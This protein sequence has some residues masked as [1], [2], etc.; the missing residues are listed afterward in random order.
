M[1]KLK[2]KILLIS[3]LL[4]LL[5]SVQSV[6][7]AADDNG[8]LTSDSIDLSICDNT[9]DVSSDKLSDNPDNILTASNELDV[10]GVDEAT[11]SNL[12]DEISAGGNVELQ[13]DYYRCSGGE[14][15]I[16]ISG[17]NRIIDGKGA[18]I[19]MAGSTIQAFNVVGS[20]VTIK[21]LTIKNA[22]YDGYGG[23]IYLYGTDNVVSNCN[24]TNNSA[25][26]GGAIYSGYFFATQEVR[27]CNFADNKATAE[28]GTGGAIYFYRATGTVENCN[29]NNNKAGGAIYCSNFDMAN[30]IVTNCNFTN[31]YA[32]EGGA[33]H[34]SVAS[35][36]NCK[37]TNNTASVYTGGAI[38]CS[39]ATVTNCNFTGNNAYRGSAIYSV[40]PSNII[41]STFLNNRANAT[42][43]KVT[44]NEANIIITF[45]GEDNLLNAIYFGYDGEFDFTNVTY[46]GADGIANTGN[47]P[48]TPYKSNNE[49]GQNITIDFYDYDDGNFIESV[50]LVTDDNG[51]AVYHYKNE[52]YK[53][54]VYH[55]EDQYYAYAE[56]IGYYNSDFG[57]FN[58]LQSYI[59]MAEANSVLDLYVDYTFTL[60]AD[61]NLAGGIVIDKQLTI[62]GNGHTINALQMARIFYI[63]SD[64]VVLNNITFANAMGYSNGGA[65]VMG[66]GTITNCNFTNNMVYIDDSSGW[67]Y[68]IGG[69]AVYFGGPGTVINCNFTNN[70][71]DSS[72]SWGY[73]GC[74]GAVYFCGNCIVTNCN[75][76]NNTASDDG[77]AIYV[78][79]GHLSDSIVENCNFTDNS[80]RCGGAIHFGGYLNAEY[81]ARN[82]NF[83]NNT[84]TDGGAIEMDIGTITNCNF[85][86]N[87]ASGYGGAII[88]YDSWES[89]ST[90]VTDCNFTNNSAC[91]GGAIDIDFGSVTNCNF[92]DNTATYAGAI[93]IRYGSITNCNFTDNQASGNGGAVFFNGNST[94]TN[95]NFTDNQASGNGGAVCFYCSGNVTNCNFMGNNASNGSA[96][97]FYNH[98]DWV[99]ILIDDGFGEYWEYIRVP[100]SCTV[101]NSC[102]LNNRAYAEALEVTAS[103]NNIIIIF[104][105]NNNLLNAIYSNDNV[106]FTNVTYWSAN[107]IATG[108]FAKP[109]RSNKEAGQ[110][111]TLEIYDSDSL[112]DNVTL[113]TDDKGQ[114]KYDLGKLSNGEYRYK[115]YHP[116]DS[117]YT[118]VEKDDAF[119]KCIG[120]FNILQGYING[121]DANSVL[122]LDRNYTFT[123]GLDENLTDGIVIDKP[124]TI[125]GNGYTINALQKARIFNVTSAKVVLN[126]IT[127]TNATTSSGGGAIFFSS[128]GTVENCNF[129][130]NT[131]TN[132][133]AIRFE[134]EG[135]VTNCNFTDNTATDGDGGAIHMDSGSVTNCNFVNNNAS[136]FGGAVYFWNE[137]KLSNCN[138]TNNTSQ[139]GGGATL[140]V[141][142]G[143]VTNCNFTNNSAECGGAIFFS[144]YENTVTNCNFINNSASI[145]GA[146]YFAGS[147]TLK[148]CNFT[149]NVATDGG[150]VFLWH[151]ST[152]ENCNFTNNV[153]TQDGGAAFFKSFHDESFTVTSCNFISNN[154]T[155]G[156]AIYFSTISC[157]NA[158]SNSIFLNNRANAEALEVT[159]NDNNITITFTGNDN[160]LNAIYSEEDVTFTNVTYWGAYGRISNTGSSP[161]TPSRSNKEAGQNITVCIAVN[162]VLVLNEVYITDEN[163]EIVLDMID[164]GNYI[165]V[166]HDADSYYTKAEKTIPNTFNVNV[167]SQTTTNKTVNITAVSNIPND[168]IKGK[169]VFVLSNSTE[170]AANYGGNGTWWALHT[171]AD[172]GVYIVNASYDGLDNVTVN[173]ATITVNKADST[174]SIGNIV[175]DYGG[176]GS[177][178][179]SF[180][181]ATG[182]DASIIGQSDADVSV[183]GN[184]I[185][186]S[187][188]DAG[189][190]TLKVTT[191]AD[192]DHNNV[193]RTADVTVR[194]VVFIT[195]DSVTGHA[196]ELVNVTAQFKYE[197]GDDVAEGDASLTVKYEDKQLLTA[198]LYS[199]LSAD[200]S[201]HVSAGKAVFS[202]KLGAPGIYPYVVSY[203]GRD[204]EDVQAESTIT[205]LKVGT[206]VSGNDISGKPSDKKNITVTVSDQSGNPVTNGTVT[207][208][209]NGKPYTVNVKKGKAVFT[210][211]L[212]NPGKYVAAVR[213][214][215]N[216]YYNSS[217]SSIGINVEKVNTKTSSQDVSGKAGEK[218][219][220]KVRI[221]DEKGNPVKNG[222]ATLTVD[223]K[224]YTAEVIDG[225]ATFEGVVLPENDTVGDVYYHGNDYY[226]ASSTTLSIKVNENNNTE[227]ASNNAGEN[228]T[229]KHVSS[230]IV[231]GSEAGNPIAMLVL[232]LFVMVIT[233]RKK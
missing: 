107:G 123:I 76:T 187:G 139:S 135:N 213:Y 113:T 108:S 12:S 206:A 151:T 82:C 8:N 122:T 71:I 11:Y 60:G 115:A 102:F 138:F 45:T 95:C 97:Y 229:A 58:R 154:A 93:Y 161:I 77:A 96:I 51:Q 116:D 224:S 137:C 166:R 178:E 103:D 33:I 44:K 40:N 48:T 91:Y 98:D 30:A 150:A 219:D 99:Q 83:I 73:S 49:A 19:D 220:I 126:N 143:T 110:N 62:N 64:N 25:L 199:I 157:T 21:N 47:T 201:S 84:A 35:F 112:V 228:K 59:N 20:G 204:V 1:D 156:S 198:S 162:D 121:A 183:K 5:V 149:N 37:F 163:G 53:Y 111:I 214:N 233:Y 9:G 196:G 207:L 6:A 171:F 175:F 78:V 42:A 209:L 200:A 81:I 158:V 146:I 211:E 170:I 27:N 14:S 61:E 46:W 92:T 226:N 38:F 179:V 118:Y 4:L 195:I 217:T 70:V 147:G 125:N 174:L 52:K 141:H 184:T 225:V 142:K 153:A 168:V 24:F 75:F 2:T 222:T 169:L 208:T 176:S 192:A 41:N 173:N 66:S 227:P 129:I 88:I 63:A 65:I 127:F 89:Y 109:S 186:V 159:T 90:T 36:E 215:G 152:F 106:T 50:T 101:S 43:F 177:T 203:S 13:H 56:K 3:L 216:D 134:L 80:A 189:K 193:T 172:Y 85:T 181:G 114:V 72:A 117:Y 94:V 140:F 218:T 221:V 29:F 104:T 130:N 191:I 148:N 164:G 188:L 144:D 67:G 28:Y 86:G 124:I 180:T 39:R 145:G 231:D 22:N 10:L 79:G 165:N 212:P 57:D 202:V 87:N 55:P 197:N 16:N 136:G 32:L 160:L 190:Y 17:D 7:A 131:A 205:I 105:G 182:V 232:A 120:D 185:T 34:M 132:G 223:G 100:S 74:G 128:Y 210:V 133:G 23:A 119:T 31:N 230:R 15:T 194:H 68:T 167:T 54:K 69:G 18:V 155:A 26:Y